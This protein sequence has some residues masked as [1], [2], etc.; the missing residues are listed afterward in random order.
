MCC[1]WEIN[2]IMITRGQD[3]QSKREYMLDSCKLVLEAVFGSRPW[4]VVCDH[5]R[6]RLQVQRKVMDLLEPTK[7]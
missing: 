3:A 5:V 2:T 1:L 6:I 7:K 4:C